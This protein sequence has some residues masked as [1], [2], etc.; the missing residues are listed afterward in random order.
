MT[1]A[2]PHTLSSTDAEDGTPSIDR[3]Q[4]NF[5]ELA[6]Q[7][8]IGNANLG[9]R[10]VRGTIVLAWA[11]AQVSAVGTVTHGLGA[12]PTSI[13][14]TV[15]AVGSGQHAFAEIGNQNAT[16]FQVQGWSV[17]AFTGNL[18]VHWVAYS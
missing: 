5:D 3:V 12:Q 6:K 17:A 9:I 18:T 1:L 14:A 11:A 7:F 15:Q 16:T 8:P 4:E 2:L 13:V 10:T